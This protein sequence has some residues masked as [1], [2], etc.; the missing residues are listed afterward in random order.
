MTDAT[1][2]VTQSRLNAFAREYL[3]TLGASIREQGSRW[4]VR[5]PSHVDVEFSDGLEFEVILGDDRVENNGDEEV[6][7]S[8]GSEFAQ[9]IL[10]EAVS[11][12]SL[13]QVSVTESL[14]GNDYQY[15]DWVNESDLHVS[16]ASFNPYYD[17]T[18]VFLLVKISVET[19]SEYETQYLEAVTVDVTSEEELSGLPEV[20]L[21]SF[22]DPKTQPETEEANDFEATNE[23]DSDT[24]T[25]VIPIGQRVALDNIRDE[26]E[27]VRETASRAADSEFEEYRQLQNQR[28][29]DLR[30]ELE[31]VTDRLQRV[32]GDVDDADT[33]EERMSALQERKELQTEKD[34]LE[35]KRAE[36]LQ[37]KQREFE[38]KREEIFVRHALDIST[39][40]VAST[41]VSYERGELEIRLSDSHRTE[42]IRAPYAAGVGCTDS[43]RCDQCQTELSADNPIQLG[44]TV[45]RCQSCS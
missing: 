4:H 16:D 34:G 18:A 43:V 20:L 38:E 35:E 13:S 44:P 7:L 33:Q 37:K 11:M 27:E 31:S 1:L 17:R 41:L 45:L 42:T 10:D 2:S 9:Q 22:Y 26:I 15:P 21:R 40:P 25:S 6:V 8:P 32:S 24:L 23:P 39:K 36:L 30:D 28:L 14:T 5:L 12:S 3:N 19:V 29:R